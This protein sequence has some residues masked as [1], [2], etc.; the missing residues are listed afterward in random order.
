M[1]GS[2]GLLKEAAQRR[3]PIEWLNQD[4]RNLSVEGCFDLAICCYNTFQH[5][6]GQSLAGAFAGVRRLLP[7]G[8][9]LAFDIYQPNRDYLRLP[10]RNRMARKIVRPGSTDLE[11]RECTDFDE[12]ASLLTISWKLVDPLRLDEPPLAST[13]YR[14]WQHDPALVERSLLEAGFETLERYGDLARS[15]FSASSKK[16]VYVCKAH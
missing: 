14:M 12:A 7:D 16:Q 8:A 4:L 2:V 1:D 9:R 3:V 10:Q 11:I 5:I 13:M 6:D 15:C